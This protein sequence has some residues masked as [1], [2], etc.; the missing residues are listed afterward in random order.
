MV[1]KKIIFLLKSRSLHFRKSN[2]SSGGQNL[3]L[4]KNS[5]WDLQGTDP[6]KALEREYVMPDLPQCAYN[7]QS[8]SILVELNGKLKVMKSI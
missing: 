8:G 2:I 6:Y 1:K 7:L 4:S 3:N 5:L